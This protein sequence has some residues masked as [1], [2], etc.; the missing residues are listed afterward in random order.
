MTA[1]KI[2]TLLACSLTLSFT[3]I[4]PP[5]YAGRWEARQ[6]VREGI[7]EVRREKREAWREIKR[8]DTR[9]CARRE[10]REGYR[11]VG[12]EKREAR[13][14]IRSELR[15]DYHGHGGNWRYDYDDDRD[16]GHDVLKGVAIGVAVMG[17]ATA[18]SKS[19]D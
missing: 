10:I 4:Q 3:F 19:G 13:R 6:E 8:C 16:R 17:V 15:D 7:R 5:A 9:E 1:S 18:I 14:E 2:T 12:R 11:E